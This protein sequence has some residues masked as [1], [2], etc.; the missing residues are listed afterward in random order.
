[1]A[2]PR[3]PGDGHHRLAGACVLSDGP[4]VEAPA[5]V[6]SVHLAVVESNV[7][8]PL[9][10]IVS[11][12]QPAICTWTAY[13]YLAAPL[14]TDD[15][16]RAHDHLAQGRLAGCPLVIRDAQRDSPVG[17]PRGDA[18]DARQAREPHGVSAE[19][20]QEQVPTAVLVVAAFEDE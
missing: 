10:L 15:L 18:A 20:V 3:R 11:T 12:D 9:P 7:P 17:S 8:E 5:V 14:V 2:A 16:T 1:V 19:R 4:G 6:D 13:R